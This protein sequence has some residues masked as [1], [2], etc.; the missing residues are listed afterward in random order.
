MKTLFQIAG[1]IALAFIMGA[2]K[3][4]SDIH[5]S[6][7]SIDWTGVYKGVESSNAKETITVLN[8]Q[9]DMTY[10]MQTASADELNKATESNGIFSWDKKGGGI[11][12]KDSKTGKKTSFQVGE[13]VLRKIGTTSYALTKIQQESITEKYWKLI[14][15]NGKPVVM[16]ES[17]G[18]EPFIILKNEGNR[19]NANGGCNSLT[20]SYEI[21]QGNRIKFSQMISTM[22]ACVHMEIETELKKALEMTDNY[23]LSADGQYLSLNRA[24]MAPLARFEAVYLR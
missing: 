7:T 21:S 15:I 18:R 4:S 22:M 16:D 11:T 10:H 3:T 8:L 2:C 24:R 17:T 1:V 9:K 23:T 12:L 19:I 13:N 6:K 14:E 20:G 5:N